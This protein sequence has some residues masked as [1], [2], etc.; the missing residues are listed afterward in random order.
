MI[1]KISFDLRMQSKLRIQSSFMAKG[2]NYG[3]GNDLKTISTINHLKHLNYVF[4]QL[5]GGLVGGILGG[6]LGQGLGNQISLFSLSNGTSPFNQESNSNLSFKGVDNQLILALFSIL[7]MILLQQRNQSF[8]G[9]PEGKL[10]G[11]SNGSPLYSPNFSKPYRFPSFSEGVAGIGFI[12]KGVYN[13]GVIPKEFPSSRIASVSGGN[14]SSASGSNTVSGGNSNSASNSNVASVSGGNSSSAS[15]SNAVS[16]GNSNSASS[17]NVASVSGGNS[18]SASG[19]N[20]VSGSN[21]DSN[22]QD[23]QKEYNVDLIKRFEGF[24]AHAY[25]DGPDRYSIGYGTRANSPDEV[26]TQEEA[27]RRLRKHVEEY[28]LPGIKNIIGEER[29]NQLDYNQKSALVSLA[30]NLGVGGATPILNLVKEGRIQEAAQE[31]KEYV[32]DSNGQVL[33]GLVSRRNEEAKLLLS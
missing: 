9:F 33:P 22:P 13:A 14:S 6:L 21:S 8:N 27:E 3:W 24:S 20:T 29:W 12:P 23:R 7:L 28:V 30:Y 16:G 25:P 11:I 5:I 31:M 17:S 1:K 10:D 2:I 26:I 19:S 15:G 18:S 32:R 4:S